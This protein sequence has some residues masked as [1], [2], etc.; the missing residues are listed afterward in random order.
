MIAAQTGRL[1]VEDYRKLPEDD[2]RYQLIDGEIVMS[3][4]PQFF[5]QRILMNLVRLL[6][7][8]VEANNLGLVLFAP[9]DFYLD[10]HNVYQPD[11]FFVSRERQGIFQEDGMHGAPDFVAEVLSRRTARYDLN[12]KRAGYARGGVRELWLV[13]PETK[14]VDVFH[15]E[16]NAETPLASY[17]LGEIFHSPLFPGLDLPT[18]AIFAR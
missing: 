3:P 7:P 12:A 1:T 6:S 8:H 10:E 18:N 14:K 13:Y 15:F 2:W 16:K 4:S 17:S 11:V 5:H 9:L